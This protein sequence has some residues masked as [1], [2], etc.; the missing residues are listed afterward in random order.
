MV[1]IFRNLFDLHEFLVMLMTLILVMKFTAKLLR[2]GYRYHKL[3]KEFSKFYRRQFD[4]VFKSNVG[5]KTLG[6]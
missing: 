6:V 2:Q 1:F 4:I 3:R 5:L